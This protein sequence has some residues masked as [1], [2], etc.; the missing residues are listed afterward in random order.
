[1]VKNNTRVDRTIYRMHVYGVGISLG[2]DYDD[3]NRG[4][5]LASRKSRK[6]RLTARDSPLRAQHN[7]ILMS[8]RAAVPRRPVGTIKTGRVSIDADGKRVR[9]LF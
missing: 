7:E 5:V 1:M 6:S 3:H 2:G 9:S 8:L 4:D